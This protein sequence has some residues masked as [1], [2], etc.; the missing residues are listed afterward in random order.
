V[1]G[2]ATTGPAAMTPPVGVTLKREQVFARGLELYMGS[3][4]CLSSARVEIVAVE[5]ANGTRHYKLRCCACMRIATRFLP[6]AALRQD[7]M[8]G[9]PVARRSSQPTCERC[10]AEGAEAHHWAP[11]AFFA[12]CDDWPM[13]YLCP[14]CHTRWHKALAAAAEKAS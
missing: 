1:Q 3:C 10:G 4:S 6:Y 5:F 9:A 11:R 14:S 2:T 13:S 7:E 12:D 8:A